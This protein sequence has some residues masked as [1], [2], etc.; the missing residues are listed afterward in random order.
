[1]TKKQIKEL[2]QAEQTLLSIKDEIQKMQQIVED[3]LKT[4]QSKEKKAIIFKE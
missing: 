4:E 2:K 3:K 1:M